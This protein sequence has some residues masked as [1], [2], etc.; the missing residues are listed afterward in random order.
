MLT[1]FLVGGWLAARG[2]DVRRLSVVPS[3]RS[4]Q[5]P[6]RRTAGGCEQVDSALLAAAREPMVPLGAAV[7]TVLYILGRLLGGRVAGLVAVGLA[8]GSPLLRD[9][10]PQA[11]SECVL[12]LWILLG[13]LLAYL[14]ARRVRR[15]AGER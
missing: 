3:V 9:Y 2:Y 12:S 11:R 6:G 13:L 8:L 14:S 5:K 10:L 7:A 15:A 1:N 4:H